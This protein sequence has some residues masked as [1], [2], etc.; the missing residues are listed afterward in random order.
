MTNI[1]IK[2]LDE[3]IGIT[4]KAV[5]EVFVE[6]YYE[7]LS[8]LCKDKKKLTAAFE[9]FINEDVFY[10]A[11]IND[12]PLGIA[13]CADNK[14]RALCLDAKK[15]KRYLGFFKGT[16]AYI[17]MKK[18][19]NTPLTQYPEGFAYI[20]CVATIPEA[21][22]KGIATE[23]MKFILCELP[24]TEYILEVTDTNIT[25]KSIYERIG[26]KEFERKKERLAKI[27]G[28]NYRIYMKINTT[29]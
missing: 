15:F 3:C 5:A 16:L 8:T 12:K 26:F 22:G 18:E 23:L 27:K 28:F 2:K 7:L 17:A 21:R 24:Y 11:V 10:V 19:F 9:S 4:K 20:E 13:A 29:K 14:G 1:E 25:A 6:G